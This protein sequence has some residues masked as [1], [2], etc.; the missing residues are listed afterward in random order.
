MAP[1]QGAPVGQHFN[2]AASPSGWVAARSSRRRWRWL[3]RVL[4]G[5]AGVALLALLGSAEARVVGEDS[6]GDSRYWLVPAIVNAPDQF[7]AKPLDIL[8][9]E[10]A[11]IPATPGAANDQL[12]IKLF[13]A[14]RP[15]D[16]SNSGGYGYCVQF[17]AGDT[18][19]YV[20]HVSDYLAGAR[21]PYVAAAE[22]EV[23]RATGANAF[24]CY[25]GAL[26][27]LADTHYNSYPSGVENGTPFYYWSFPLSKVAVG[28]SLPADFTDVRAYTL[29]R[30]VCQP[31]FGGCGAPMRGH[32]DNAGPWA[33]NW[34]EPEMPA[35]A[36]IGAE[37][38]KP[39]DA[40]PQASGT[41]PRGERGEAKAIPGVGHGISWPGTVAI[42]S[43]LIALALVRR[44]PPRTAR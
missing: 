27:I 30:S 32:A 19:Y 42:L 13:I 33:V 23:D 38:N 18:G 4:A 36:E 14:A 6:R 2:T 25:S 3:G 7:S 12:S 37:K 41:G 34:T 28:N 39:G 8:R 11:L 20:Q 31:S 1:A 9:L 44:F 22:E 15:D 21:V 26:T 16:N 10:M 29:S 5:V 17:K 24:G 43:V 40:S 35:A